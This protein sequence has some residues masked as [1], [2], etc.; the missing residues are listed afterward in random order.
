MY[1]DIYPKNEEEAEAADADDR[2]RRKVMSTS[3]LLKYQVQSGE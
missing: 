3:T 2:H 1:R